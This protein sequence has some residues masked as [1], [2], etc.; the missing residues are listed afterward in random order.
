MK[1][2]FVAV[3]LSIFIYILVINY[4]TPMSIG[5]DYLYAF[6]WQ[7]HSMFEPLSEDAVRVQS[8]QDLV[9]SQLS[10]YHTWGGRVVGQTLAQLFAWW[11]KGLFNICNSL[12]AIFL[13]AEIYWCSNKGNINLNMKTGIICWIFFALWAFV[14][15]CSEVFFWLTGACVFLW[16]A[17]FLWGFLLP[18][19]NKF[20]SSQE[21]K[22]QSYLY[23]FGMFG[24]GVI[25]GCGNENSI[26]WIILTLLFFLYLTNKSQE[27]ELWMYTGVAGLITGYLLLMLAPG[28]F[29]RLVGGHGSNW[30]HL[31]LLKHHF[32]ILLVVLLFQSP[33][34]YFS[35]R[36]IYSLRKVK[37]LNS[38]VQK[39]FL[40]LKA[41]LVISFG[42][43][44][45]MLLSPEFPTRSGFPGT[46]P[47]VI[48]TCILLRIQKENGVVLIHNKVKT[49][50]VGLGTVFFLVTSSVSLLNYYEKYIYMQEILSLAKQMKN[51][52]V[53]NVLCVEP[54]REVS[55]SENL[56]SGLHVPNYNFAEE[57]NSWKNVAFARYYGVK[58]IRLIKEYGKKYE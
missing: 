16:P 37:F 30:Y 15:G 38:Y 31:S 57:V 54:F 2:R 21:K 4:L 40:L 56:I 36:S 3:F 23:C 52:S 24:F 26:G 33:M 28:N 25:A 18:Y 44:A 41:L 43:S 32:F 51:S 53:L 50:F 1:K 8:V 42:M 17:S 46:V 13:I 12:I 45:T 35:L 9:I 20:Y 49:F 14:P 48:A 22:S 55:F 47:L 6:I 27:Q 19:I 58:G 11:G 7:G 29:A 5:D 39:D 34:W 10:L